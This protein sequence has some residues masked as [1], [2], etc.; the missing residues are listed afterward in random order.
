MINLIHCWRVNLHWWQQQK[1][2]VLVHGCNA[3]Y[4]TWYD[5]YRS[6]SVKEKIKQIKNTK[7]NDKEKIKR[8][9]RAIAWHD[10]GKIADRSKLRINTGKWSVV[11]MM[12]AITSKDDNCGFGLDIND[13]SISSLWVLSWAD[14]F[15]NYMELLNFYHCFRRTIIRH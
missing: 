13:C 6:R 5:K 11:K 8:C 14:L 3:W 12:T 15:W 7:Q 4:N 9:R 2:M 10:G 1:R